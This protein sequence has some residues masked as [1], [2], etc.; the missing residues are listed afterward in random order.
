[1]GTRAK[2]LAALTAHLPASPK[3][4]TAP[5]GSVS[6]PPPTH[7]VLSV[8]MTMK[9]KPT[10]AAA[11]PKGVGAATPTLSH[12]KTPT[13]PIIG[14]PTVVTTKLPPA[15]PLSV[16]VL[17]ASTSPAP[18]VAV[19]GASVPGGAA[20]SAKKAPSVP[21]KPRASRTPPS[22]VPKPAG[23]SAN[24]VQTAVDPALIVSINSMIQGLY[25]LRQSKE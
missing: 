23:A 7:S 25:A 18:S 20:P 2:K 24:Q 1:M 14:P 3:S 15:A 4:A 13:G 10:V 19:P 8:T 17:G 5:V 21:T 9:T 12:P 6:K 11:A 22:S 16:S